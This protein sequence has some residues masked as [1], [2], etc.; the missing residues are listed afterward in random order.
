MPHVIYNTLTAEIDL[1]EDPGDYPSNAGQFP[2]PDREFVS[3]ISGEVKLQVDQ[4]DIL[5]IQEAIECNQLNDFVNDLNLKLPYGIIFP[6]WH[7]EIA[8]NHAILCVQEFE[9][10]YEQQERQVLQLPNFNQ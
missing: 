1:W 9:V 6:K 7:I 2:L 10:N 8:G 5:Q 4:E 3:E